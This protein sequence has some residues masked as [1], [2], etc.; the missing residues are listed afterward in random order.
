MQ[1]KKLIQVKYTLEA[2]EEKYEQ[3]QS[4]QLQYKITQHY[5]EGLDELFM[6]SVCT[7]IG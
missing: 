7:F 4:P 5:T 3:K 6:H 2:S 1:T